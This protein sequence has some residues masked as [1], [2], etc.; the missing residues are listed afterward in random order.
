[1][2][3][4]VAA[5][6]FGI[7][8][9]QLALALPQD[10]GTVMLAFDVSGSMQ[11]TDVAPT[12]M[13]AAK[14]AAREFV[15]Q[16]PNWVQI[17]VVAFNQSA[18]LLQAPTQDRTLVLRAID[19]LTANGGTNIGDGL[20]ESLDAMQ[21]STNA[22]AATATA[23]VRNQPTATAQPSPAR[24]VAGTVILLS[25][26]KSNTGPSALDVAR[27]A[28][29]E[30]V[31]VNTVGVGTAAGSILRIQGQTVRAD[32]DE[33][34]LRGVADTTGGR[35]FSAQDASQLSQ[36]YHSLAHQRQTETKKV[37]LTVFAIGAALALTLAGAAFS[38][39]WFNR[40]P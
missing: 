31:K 2:L 5:M 10:S 9:P 12:R 36:V 3:L 6:V 29:D 4:A 28:A 16:Q 27:T 20:Q 22:P 34:T 19:R 25:D 38:L 7:A 18:A 23:G 26:G 37:D 32:L 35:Y 33:T 11:A 1:M 8:R 30:G 17:G 21:G 15:S 24:P 13:E 40:L 14:T 39:L